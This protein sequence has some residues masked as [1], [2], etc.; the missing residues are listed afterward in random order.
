MPKNGAYFVGV[1]EG[2]KL[3]PGATMLDRAAGGAITRA[4]DASRF[5]GASD[6][7][8][9]V[10]APNGLQASRVLLLGLGK[11]EKFDRQAAERI[12]A[13]IVTQ[14]QNSGESEASVLV[15]SIA[16]A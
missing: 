8:L 14:L 12:G 13:R 2:R 7:A 4:I 9:T 1:L 5:K 16:G 3:L 15:D 6:H 11:P 10:L